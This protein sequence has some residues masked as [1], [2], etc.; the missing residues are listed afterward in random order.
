MRILLF[1]KVFCPTY[2][3]TKK[4]TSHLA[5]SGRGGGGELE[6]IP[7]FHSQLLIEYSQ[8]SGTSIHSLCLL[9]MGFGN[10]NMP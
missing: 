10:Q 5:V 7:L 2:H 1:P 4:C 9:Q 8:Y 6:L 3:A